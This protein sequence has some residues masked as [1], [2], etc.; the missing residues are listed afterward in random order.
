MLDRSQAE[1]FLAFAHVLADAAGKVTL[2][3]FRTSLSVDNKLPGGFDPVTEADRGAEAAIRALIE[4]AYPD[5]GIWGEEGGH[6]PGRSGLTWVIDPVDGTR[7]FITGSPLW[8]TL[9]ALNDGERAVIGILDQPFLDERFWGVSLPTWREAGYARGGSKRGLATRACRGLAHA[10]LSTTTIELFKQDE[11]R[12]FETLM[13]RTRLT[14]FGG[15]CYQYALVAMGFM[16]LV[17]ETSNQ[18]YDVQ[19]L[20]PI[21]EGA[22]GAFTTW[23]G[24]AAEGGGRVIAA[25]DPRTHAE[26]LEVLQ[27]ALG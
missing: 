9:I 26:A 4:E 21:I 10:A 17:V 14:R 11:R 16:D 22:G 5:H 6:A 25:G 8:G 1:E 3:Y 20:I 12:A 27:A 18:P 24:A 15:D 19:A 23:D 7:A 13:G 2:P